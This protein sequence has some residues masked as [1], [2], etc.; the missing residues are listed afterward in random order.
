MSFSSKSPDKTQKVI[1][2]K[3]KK[4]KSKLYGCPI[5]VKMCQIPSSLGFNTKTKANIISSSYFNLSLK[6]K[7]NL[8]LKQVRNKNKQRTSISKLTNDINT[9]YYSLSITNNKTLSNNNNI[10]NNNNSNNYSKYLNNSLLTNSIN[11]SK[12]QANRKSNT[13]KED[14]I[15]FDKQN[16]NN[17]SLKI[18]VNK[19]KNAIISN[20][21]R[22]NSV[23]NNN[24]NENIN[25][26][27]NNFAHVTHNSSS[28]PK[29]LQKNENLANNQFK[30][31]TKS[32][33]KKYYIRENRIE[34]KKQNIKSLFKKMK[35]KAKL[36]L[37]YSK[38]ENYKIKAKIG[39]HSYVNINDLSC[40]NQNNRKNKTNQKI[41]NYSRKHNRNH[42]TSCNKKI[43]D[44]L[45][46]K[47]IRNKKISDFILIDD[48]SIKKKN[49]YQTDV[50]N[51]INFDNIKLKKLDVI[52]P[53]HKFGTNIIKNNMTNDIKEVKIRNYHSISQ[54]I[55]NLKN[56]I[57]KLNDNY[58]NNYNSN[59]SSLYN[60]RK[61][62]KDIP[63]PKLT[64]D[65]KPEI[66]EK[67]KRCSKSIKGIK[68]KK[69]NINK[70]V[71]ILSKQKN[72]STNKTNSKKIK[73]ND[74]KNCFPLTNDYD[75]DDYELEINFED[76]CKEKLNIIDILK[77]NNKN[78]S[79]NE[80]KLNFI[81]LKIGKNNKNKNKRLSPDLNCR[82]NSHKNN[83]MKNYNKN[84]NKPKETN[85][86]CTNLNEKKN[87]Y[88][89][90][91]DG[92]GE[93]IRKNNIEN[94]LFSE[95]NL[96]DIDKIVDDKY[97]DLYSII[98][99]INFSTVLLNNEGVF[100]VENK[101]YQN[102]TQVF[103][104]YFD[105]LYLK[106]ISTVKKGNKSSKGKNFSSSTKVNTTSYKKN[107][108]K[109]EKNE[110]EEF[111]L[112]M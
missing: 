81:S 100:N 24:K 73:N 54:N 77:L 80:K 1:N 103:N 48:P 28:I 109:N 102:H 34:R 51:N 43:I 75:R 58:L 104:S 78:K 27:I 93:E 55:N 30:L 67:K 96:M 107:S 99:W 23:K 71:N 38:K 42:T 11:K 41:Y 12:K 95:N 22:N 86:S 84:I 111:K 74:N 90:I 9:N 70:N 15:T 33:N 79:L 60:K 56:I 40:I 39:E 50:L 68:I 92:T 5:N 66:E 82:L 91:D 63:I 36:S 108:Y 17:N 32:R 25:F 59:N 18:K 46:S 2:K 53:K 26:N 16:N 64:K 7:T 61:I 19:V 87:K 45:L 101:V 44:S 10:S 35:S 85:H 14:Y 31:R 110:I 105:K 94:N 65:K 62:L 88:L 3:I 29:N 112:L 52:S 106:N 98:K 97:D 72:N 57:S 13:I 83:A 69:M 6:N 89:R 37:S 49:L 20:S 21:S 4:N 8:I 47:N 76:Y